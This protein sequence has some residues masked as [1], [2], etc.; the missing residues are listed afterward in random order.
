[1]KVFLDDERNTPAGWYRVY[2][3]FQ[4]IALLETGQVSHISLDHDLGDDDL[5]GTG[6]DVLIWIEEQVA[7]NNFEPPRIL[8]HSA[9]PS[10]GDKMRAGIKQIRK[11][12]ENRDK[13]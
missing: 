5:I 12:Y 9:N 11:I 10:A 4:A 3:P 7:T 2:E 13:V 1:M 8:V 6:N